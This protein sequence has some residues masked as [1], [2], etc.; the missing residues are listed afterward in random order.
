MTRFAVSAVGPDRPGLI[1]GLAG[2]LG[3]LGCNCEDS[4]MR[5][6]NNHAAMMIVVDAPTNL[7]ERRFADVLAERA[8]EWGLRTAVWPLTV[9]VDDGELVHNEAW[10][11]IIRGADRLGIMDEVAQLVADHSLSISDLTTRRALS[12]EGEVVFE[13]ALE[14]LLPEGADPSLLANGLDQICSTLSLRCQLLPPSGDLFD[15]IE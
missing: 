8:S 11:V 7:S 14:V 5:V 15:G 10:A 3:E 9:L 4:C 2:V 13:M 12:R 1:A 6:L